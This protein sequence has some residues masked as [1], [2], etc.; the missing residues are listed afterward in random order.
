MI[1]GWATRNF[2]NKGCSC[3]C[4]VT[5][6]M[7]QSSCHYSH[8]KGPTSIIPGAVCSTF[9]AHFSAGVPVLGLSGIVVDEF[10]TKHVF[11]KWPNNINTKRIFPHDLRI[12]LKIFFTTRYWDFVLHLFNTL[13]TCSTPLKSHFNINMNHFITYDV[14]S[15]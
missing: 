3:M 4:Q 10:L 15:F 7:L 13:I 11:K 8:H 1:F 12:Y 5:K 9:K 14:R 6:Q 2:C